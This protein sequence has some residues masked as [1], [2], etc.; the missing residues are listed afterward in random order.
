MAYWTRPAS[1]DLRD[2]GRAGQSFAR[3]GARMDNEETNRAYSLVA[4]DAWIA[5]IRLLS[6]FSGRQPRSRA[7]AAPQPMGNRLCPHSVWIAH[8]G[9]DWSLLGGS[10]PLDCDRDFEQNR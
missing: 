3:N 10:F 8:H 9:G 4:F 2:R 6:S 1:L 5:A 7:F